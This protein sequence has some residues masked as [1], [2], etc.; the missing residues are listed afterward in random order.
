[1]TFWESP[2]FHAYEQAYGD[3]PGTRSNL[4]ATAS[5]S[6]RVIDLSV[7]EAELWRGIRKS[8]KA[9]I[10]QA[11]RT[12][13]IVVCEP[14]DIEGFRLV[15]YR[16]AGR[17][18]RPPATWA[19][20]GD[21]LRSGH[22]VLIGAVIGSKWYA[23]ACFAGMGDSAYYFSAAATKQNVNHALI[24]RAMKHLKAHGVKQLE[25][26][27]QGQA[28]DEKGKAIEFFRTGFGGVDKPA[29]FLALQS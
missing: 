28:A 6:T 25:M 13:E 12:H 24:W 4:L 7:T 2:Q 10:H 11:E 16:E 9:L 21:W 18:T 3:E 19:V 15:H 20:M 22:A 27:W 14:H 17:E 23:F 1:M 8:Y 29:N 5:W 26:G